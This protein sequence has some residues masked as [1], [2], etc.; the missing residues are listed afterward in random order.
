MKDLPYVAWLQGWFSQGIRDQIGWTKKS[1]EE[2]RASGLI[3]VS[4]FAPVMAPQF[5]PND[6]MKPILSALRGVTQDLTSQGPEAIAR[7]AGIVESA[8]KKDPA[9]WVAKSM[10]ARLCDQETG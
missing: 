6:E 2:G 1:P 4:L 3:F 5:G 9:L 10:C 8:A 7:A